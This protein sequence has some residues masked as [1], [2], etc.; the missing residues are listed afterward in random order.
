MK[1][2]I[3]TL[4]LCLVAIS[5]MS[6]PP[7]FRMVKTGKGTPVIL[8]PGFATPGSVWN[9]TVANLKGDYQ[10]HIVTYAGFDG[11]APIDTP[12]YSHIKSALIEYIDNEKLTNIVIIGHSMGGTLAADL[13][14]QVPDKVSK[15]VLVDALPCMR[16]VMMPG[17]SAAQIQYNSPYNN[18]QLSQ[19]AEVFRNNAVMMAGYMASNQINIDSLTNWM[20]AADRKTYVYGYTDLLRLDV[21][22]VLNKVKAETLILGA[23]V[24]YGETAVKA[25]LEKQYEQ[26]KEKTILIAPN[27]KHFIMFDQPTW[28]YEQ[29]NTFLK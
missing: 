21:R 6:Q 23:P 19:S 8:L 18:Q 11:V 9:E 13:A 17:V 1:S 2:V 14:A 10:K 24:P 26:L 5:S 20:V 16:E 3:S 25:N 7:A 4:I 28:F 15:L 22:D 27:S 29:V 12:W